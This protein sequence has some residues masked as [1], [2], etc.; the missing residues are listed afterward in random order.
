MPADLPPV[1]LPA[2]VILPAPLVACPADLTPQMLLPP[3][4]PMPTWYIP[5]VYPRPSQL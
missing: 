2:P 5:L 1:T 3:P 4:Q